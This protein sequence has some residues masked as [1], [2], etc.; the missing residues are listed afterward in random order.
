VGLEEA[1]RQEQRL[2]AL[3]AQH[4]HRQRRDRLDTGRRHLDDLV[5]ADCLRIL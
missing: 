2:L 3:A 4:L 1:D 5:V